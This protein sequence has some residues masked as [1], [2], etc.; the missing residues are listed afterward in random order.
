MYLELIAAEIAK[1][2]PETHHEYN[3]ADPVVFPYA[4]YGVY[5]DQ[6]PDDGE[7]TGTVDIELYDNS[8][9]NKLP[10][11]QLNL[12]L[13]QLFEKGFMQDDEDAVTS[14]FLGSRSIPTPGNTINR[15][16]IQILIK[17]HNRRP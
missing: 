5:L 2:V 1:V 4:V 3:N 13:I 15:K 6:A 17:I 12:Q 8:G 11:E 9:N 14:Q 16:L 10:I 7:M